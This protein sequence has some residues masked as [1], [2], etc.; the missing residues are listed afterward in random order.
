[1]PI[2]EWKNSQFRPQR[3]PHFLSL[4]AF[5]YVEVSPYWSSREIFNVNFHLCMGSM[6]LTYTRIVYIHMKVNIFMY[7]GEITCILKELEKIL[8]FIFCLIFIYNF[9]IGILCGIHIGKSWHSSLYEI[10]FF[11]II[12]NEQFLNLL[13]CYERSPW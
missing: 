9:L 1:M 3:F 2:K 8:F 6:K 4:G 12:N 13:C 10:F 11:F 5:F 7:K